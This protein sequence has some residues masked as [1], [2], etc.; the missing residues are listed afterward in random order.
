MYMQAI[1]LELEKK[2][3]NTRHDCCRY[4]LS[5]TSGL[6]YTIDPRYAISS[7]RPESLLV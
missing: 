5:V 3:V 2:L 7:C 6:Y 1:G 4:L